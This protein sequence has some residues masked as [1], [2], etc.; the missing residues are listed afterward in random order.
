MEEEVDNKI[1]YLD[2]LVI[3][4]PDQ[5]LATQWYAKPIA[6]GRLLNFHSFHPLSMKVNLAYIYIKRVKT[7]TTN[8]TPQELKQI[9]FKNLRLNEYPAA[10]INRLVNQVQN[11]AEP[12]NNRTAAVFNNTQVQQGTQSA[13]TPN[14]NTTNP[15]EAAVFRSLPYIPTLTPALT[16]VLKK[17]FP[18]VK[19]A[20]KSIQTTSQILK[21]V[22]D[23]VNPLQQYNVIYSIPCGNC[24]MSYIGLTTNQLKTRL[25]GHRANI[26]KYQKL[27]EG[28]ITNTDEQ[29][30]RLGEITALLEHTINYKHDFDLTQVKIIDKTFKPSALSVLEMCHIANTDKTVNRRT[31]VYGLSN[32]Y[33]GILHTIKP[34][35]TRRNNPLS[36]I[37]NHTQTTNTQ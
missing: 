23:P 21:N 27:V 30:A 36:D 4:N 11:S 25:S 18:N 17:D 7:L 5:T 1:P 37:S 20:Q 8:Q 13:T 9:I 32:T 33:S 28:G 35:V 10:L 12:P 6:S 29:L 31:D 3:R 16:S 26:N 22:K 14:S 2:T 15:P 34:S 24:D 19:I